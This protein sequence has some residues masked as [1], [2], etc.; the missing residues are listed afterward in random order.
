[1]IT[2]RAFLIGAGSTLTMPLLNKFEWHIENLG[3]PFIEATKHTSS[4]LY[5]Y[6]DRDFQIGL[7][8]DPWAPNFPA[9]TWR[10]LFV[11]E[12][13]FLPE[14]ERMSIEEYAADWGLEPLELDEEIPYD[15]LLEI[16]ER[17]GPGA[18]AHMLLSGLDI[19]PD[20][21]AGNQVGGL[22]FYD[23]PMPGSNYLGVEADDEISVSLLQHR[24]NELRMGIAVEIVS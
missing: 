12:W 22:K 23:G 11:D 9:M 5:V 16:F 18:D 19:G 15:N 6:P 3:R 14:T 13:G 7:D 8:G 24:L 10:Q 4:T 21:C 1:M 2:R 20:L 17:K